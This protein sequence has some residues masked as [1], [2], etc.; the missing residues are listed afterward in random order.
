MKSADNHLNR[1]HLR[2]NNNTLH[3]QLLDMANSLSHPW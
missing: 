3:Y 1:R 2:E